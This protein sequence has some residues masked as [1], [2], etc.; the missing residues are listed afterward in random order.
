VGISRRTRDRPTV[1]RLECQGRDVDVPS[2]TWCHRRR[3]NVGVT[4]RRGGG[5]GGVVRPPPRRQWVAGG[6]GGPGV[7]VDV[8][9]GGWSR[10]V[11]VAIVV[12]CSLVPSRGCRGTAVSAVSALPQVCLGGGNLWSAGPACH[13]HAL[14]LC[15]GRARQGE[16]AWHHLLP[17]VCARCGVCARPVGG[18]VR[19]HVPPCCGV[20]LSFPGVFR[21]ATPIHSL[22]TLALVVSS[23]PRV[24]LTLPPRWPHAPCTCRRAALHM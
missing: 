2:L 24:L 21:L 3:R 20:V 19:V 18:F 5:G 14:L 22:A 16:A 12:C 8:R 10:L 4:P 7:R 23:G 17:G 6:E 13:A 11:V 15:R 9:A 1:W